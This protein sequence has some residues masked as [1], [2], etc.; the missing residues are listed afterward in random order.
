MKRYNGICPKCKLRLKEIEVS[1]EGASGKVKSYQC[2]KC[3]YLEFDKKTGK[4][5]IEE[6]KERAGAISIKQKIIKI[7][8]DRLGTYFNENIVRSLELKGGE[9]IYVTAPDKK[10]ILISIKNHP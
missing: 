8:H 10:T 9:E 5:V 3:G 1:V 6:L 4:K 2:R 7:S